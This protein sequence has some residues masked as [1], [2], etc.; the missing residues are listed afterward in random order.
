MFSNFAITLKILINMRN[1]IFLE[2]PPDISTHHINFLSDHHSI[3]G[4][5]NSLFHDLRACPGNPIVCITLF[6]FLFFTVL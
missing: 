3:Q 5:K 6:Y 2:W 4:E 1:A